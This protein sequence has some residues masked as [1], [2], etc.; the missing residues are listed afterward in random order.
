MSMVSDTHTP[1]FRST[2]P[3]RFRIFADGLASGPGRGR[4]ADGTGHRVGRARGRGGRDRGALGILA[5]H[6]PDPDKFVL[7][8][9][10]IRVEV[11]QYEYVTHREADHRAY[12]APDIPMA[13]T[14]DDYAH[15]RDP[16]LER[17]KAVQASEVGEFYAGTMS[18]FDRASQR[19]AAGG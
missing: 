3:L 4:G 16:I 2:Y 14:F 8:H 11:S 7:P 13:L 9:S 10:G 17:A 1:A 5:E 12:V 6:V 18:A 19:G 15:G